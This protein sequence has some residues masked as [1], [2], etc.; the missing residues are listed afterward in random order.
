MANQHTPGPW[1]YILNLSADCCADCGPSDS[2]AYPYLIYAGAEFVAKIATDQYCEESKDEA[3]AQLIAA[4]PDMLALLRRASDSL[5]DYCAEINGD[6]ND[7]LAMEIDELL[8]K[9]QP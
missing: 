3:N 2:A 8:K 1:R 5:Q 6:L 7:S 4:A 9:V